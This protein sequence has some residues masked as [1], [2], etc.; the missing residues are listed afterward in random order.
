MQ[1]ILIIDDD[2][3][4]IFALK[5]VLK[6]KG[7]DCLSAL[8]AEEGIGLLENAPGSIRVVLMDVMM[9]DMDGYEAIAR[10]RRHGDLKRHVLI[11]V[12]AQAMPGDREK[13]LAS[14]ADDYISKPIH[15]DGLLALLKKYDATG[16]ATDRILPDDGPSP[17]G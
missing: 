13:A 8:S 2:A 7:Y 14:G 12:T 5:A 6:A 15:L 10:I 11:A 3:R 17:S 1:K 4:N 9:P 16:P